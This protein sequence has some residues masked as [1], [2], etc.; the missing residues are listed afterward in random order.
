MSND[1]V[2][3]VARAL[4]LADPE[5]TSDWQDY[6]FDAQAALAAIR[7]THAIVPREHVNSEALAELI[8]MDADLLR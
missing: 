8:A 7:E 2:E 1:I 5:G 4:M 3:A 6:S